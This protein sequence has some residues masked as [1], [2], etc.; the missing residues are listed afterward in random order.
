MTTSRPTELRRYHF[1]LSQS[2]GSRLHHV[3][4]CLRR[5]E[6]VPHDADSRRETAQSS[7]LLSQIPEDR[8]THYVDLEL[9][10][11]GVALLTVTRPVT[12]DGQEIDLPLGLGLH[13]PKASTDRLRDRLRRLPW[14]SRPWEVHPLLEHLS[15]SAHAVRDAGGDPCFPDD[16]DSFKDALE[17]ARSLLFLHAGLVALDVENDRAERVREIHIGKAKGLPALGRSIY[18]LHGEWSKMTPQVDQDGEPLVYEFGPRKGQRVYAMEMHEEVAELLTQPLQDALGSVRNDPE[19]RDT[20][21][22]VVPGKVSPYE[23]GDDTPS[24]GPRVE[25]EGAQ[26]VYRNDAPRYGLELSPPTFQEPP[27]EIVWRASGL[28]TSSD[29]SEPLPDDVVEALAAGSVELLVTTA[30]EPDGILRGEVEL[31]VDQ[32]D[33]KLDLEPIGGADGGGS[34]TLGLGSHGLMFEVSVTKVSDRPTL[35]FRHCDGDTSL[36][37]Q[38]LTNQQGRGTVS[39]EVKNWAPRYLSSYV[40]FLDA[41]GEVFDPPDWEERAP[42]SVREFLQPD[43]KKKWVGWVGPDTALFSVPVDAGSEVIEL[44]LPEGAYG[45]RVLLGGLGHGR[46]FDASVCALGIGMTVVVDM[47]VPIGLLVAGAGA[48]ASKKVQEFF[49]K[50]DNVVALA[51]ILGPLGIAESSTQAILIDQ[52]PIPVLA[53]AVN[54]LGPVLAKAGLE[55]LLAH[56]LAEGALTSAIPILR[57]VFVLIKAGTTISGLIQTAVSIFESPFVF[58]LELGRTMRLRATLY[59]DRQTRTFPDLTRELRTYLLYD[60]EANGRIHERSVHWEGAAR[61]EPYPLELEDVPVGGKVKLVAL[62]YSENGWQAGQGESDWYSAEPPAGSDVLEIAEIPTK[63]NEVPLTVNTRYRHELKFD[64]DPAEGYRW[65]KSAA[66]DEVDLSRSDGKKQLRSLDHITFNG[67]G[68]RLGY[69]WQA[70]GLG[71]PLDGPDGQRI[72]DF[73]YA[74]RTVSIFRNAPDAR[75]L[76]IGWSREAGLSF[77]RTADPDGRHFLVEASAGRFDPDRNPGGGFHLRRLD[78]E[79]PLASP[80]SNR[81]WGR[82]SFPPASLTVHHGGTVIGVSRVHSK[83]GILRPTDEAVADEKAPCALL[84]SGPGTAEGLLGD[85]VA[86]ATALDGRILVLE[87]GNH[88]VQAFDQMANPVYTFA[89]E[90]CWFPL[91]RADRNTRPI[92]M[93]IEPK[94]HVFVLS[95]EDRGGTRDRSDFHLDVYRPDGTFLARTDAVNAG[96]ICVSIVRNVYTLN[97]EMLEGADGRPEP[98]VS[99]WLPSPPSP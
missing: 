11:D 26:W 88:R 80:T 98:S 41:S 1:D 74:V 94:G 72:D 73:E 6:L 87:A 51:A 97:F 15:L 22:S 55:K 54:V 34:A 44:P 21:W 60:D 76:D 95:Y 39:L 3:S 8:L 40:Q 38:P 71:L 14:E 43:A 69:A 10:S 24:A 83:L 35:S 59:P 33:V 9:P 49:D 67:P 63:T 66:P 30:Q 57:L 90:R 84:L 86:V 58:N 12:M 62:F 79:G 53:R 75:S 7:P 28:W 85:P 32:R 77:D 68:A 70:T 4:A 27:T 29:P 82:F 17:T 64:H 2:R 48:G 92:D 50:T 56:V 36:Y 25:T 42:D 16:H 61:H 52:S 93:A 23:R 65:R 46:D 81:S 99:L 96:K 18:S 91:E 13:I 78:L 89:G 19:L 31:E 47:V 20:M 45:V 5:H 37:S